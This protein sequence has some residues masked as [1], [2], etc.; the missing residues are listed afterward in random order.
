MVYASIRTKMKLKKKHMGSHTDSKMLMVKGSSI[1]GNH[2]RLRGA[3]L[4]S[5]STKI[6][7]HKFYY[8]YCIID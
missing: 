6:N 3:I 2:H 1:P 5:E 8:I 7:Y 4:L